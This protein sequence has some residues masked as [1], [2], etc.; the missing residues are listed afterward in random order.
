L[1]GVCAWCEKISSGLVKVAPR[2]TSISMYLA[3]NG[4]GVEQVSVK[5]NELANLFDRYLYPVWKSFKSIRHH[6]S[7]YKTDLPELM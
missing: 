6:G 5:K 2:R 4:C 7:S 3:Q 1:T